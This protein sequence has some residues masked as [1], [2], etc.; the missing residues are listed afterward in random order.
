MHV[1]I[2]PNAFKHSLSGIEVAKAIRKGLEESGLA[3]DFTICPVADGGEGM[4]EILVNFW[5]GTY[6][7]A[8]VQDPLGRSIE[9]V[10]GLINNGQTAIIELAQASG[11]K[12]LTSQERNPLRASTYGTGQ[13][14]KAASEAGARDFIIGVG[15]SATVDGGTGL[16]QALGVDF[17]DTDNQPLAPGAASLANLSQIKLTNLDPRLAQSKI[18]VVCDVNN[19]LLGEK[20]AARVFGPQKGADNAMVEILEQNLTQLATIIQK[21]LDK[22]ITKLPHGGAAGGTAAGLAGV[23][24]AELVPGTAYILRQIQF[25]EIIKNADLLITAEG[26]LDE[27][28]LAG[29]GPYAVAEITKQYHVPVIALAGQLPATL[30]LSKFKFFDVVLPISAGPVSLPEALTQTAINLQR[31]ACQVGKFWQMLVKQN[32]KNFSI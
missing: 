8:T 24:N 2:S 18:T 3:A 25:E 16:L 13:L 26:G 6:H 1:V 4:M 10:F 15:N 21:D 29:K 23:L 31:T 19:Y 11:L 22:D 9:A 14:L 5:Q 27:Q 12:Y 28:T 20:G 7:T 17:W 32:K 30:D